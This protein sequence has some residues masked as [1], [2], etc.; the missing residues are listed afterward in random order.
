[1][2]YYRSIICTITFII[3]ILVLC[4]CGGKNATSVTDTGEYI[5]KEINSIELCEANKELDVKKI[6]NDTVYNEKMFYGDHDL[7]GGDSAKE[8]LINDSGYYPSFTNEYG[9]RV[10]LLPIEIECGKRTISHTCSKITQYEWGRIYFQTEE[11]NLWFI[12]CAY[13]VL[14]N[15]VTFY[16]LDE[17]K[18]DKNSSAISYK[19]SDFCFEY[20]YEF[21]GLN[22]VIKKDGKSVILRSGLD[23]KDNPYF[24]ADC[25]ISNN[26]PKIDDIDHIVIHWDEESSYIHFENFSHTNSIYNSS[27]KLLDDGTFTISIPY[28]NE[29][30]TYQFACFYCHN[31][32]LI[33]I[34]ENNTYY[35]NGSYSDQYSN[36]LGN[37]ITIEDS[38][39][40]EK[41][42]E[43][44]LKEIVEK[45]ENL[46][47]DLSSSFKEAGINVAI[48]ELNGEI[49]MDSSVLF[50]GDSSVITNEGKDLLKR[51]V[52]VYSSVVFDEKYNGFIS[53]IRVEGHTAPVDGSTY[54]S[55]LPLSQERANNVKY[56]CCSSE[57]GTDQ[58]Y[59]VSLQKTMKALGMS[60]S[61]PV[62]DED[63]NVNMAL[64]RRVSF[65]FIVNLDY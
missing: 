3:L 44:K 57:I 65:R 50:G 8:Q 64:S 4:A 35:Y 18:Y 15:K 54:E 26:S 52:T 5:F 43:K 37:T 39:K 25:Y 63:G 28:E 17:F 1:M 60:N 48:D 56:Y 29:T 47:S 59:I 21:E 33:L 41:I 16:P 55:G 38:T 31:D 20:E 13:K 10:S 27:A 11:N 9:K 32:G 19:L 62:I 45:K 53:E 14:E 40:L 23:T 51:F 30:K 46:S 22:L 24:H 7:L 2:K 36:S 49:T 61:K 42:D 12:E 6:F 58:K 34:D